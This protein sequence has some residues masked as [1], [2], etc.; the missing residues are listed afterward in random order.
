MALKFG[1]QSFQNSGLRGP[2]FPYYLSFQNHLLFIIS[3]DLYHFVSK[4]ICKSPF[5]LST[6]YSKDFTQKQL[7]ALIWTKIIKWTLLNADEVTTLPFWVSVCW[8][9]H[10]WDP[11]GCY[12]LI[13]SNPKAFCD[14]NNF[15]DWD[16]FF[17]I[18]ENV[19]YFVWYQDQLLLLSSIDLHNFASLYFM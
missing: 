14:V 16:L 1:T 11:L 12:F 4:L 7:V 13:I 8:K 2:G 3:L 18:I 17:F 6:I 10:N 5:M 19:P 15:F 9:T